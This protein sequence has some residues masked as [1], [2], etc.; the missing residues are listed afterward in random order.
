MRH[1]VLAADYDG[2]LAT[3]GR[4]DETTLDALRR[5]RARPAASSSW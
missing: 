1:L 3:Q 5:L 4:V 2:T